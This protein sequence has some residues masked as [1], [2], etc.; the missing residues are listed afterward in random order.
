MN[1]ITLDAT[2]VSKRSITYHYN[3]NGEWARFFTARRKYTITYDQNVANV[4]LSICNIHFVANIL[5]LAWLCNATIKVHELDLEFTQSVPEI[6]KGYMDMYPKTVFSGNLAVENSI[7]N[8]YTSTNQVA[9][10]FSGGLDAMS[11]VASHYDEHPLLINIQGSD[12]NLC[13][14][15]IITTVKKYLTSMAGDLGL[16]ITFI[17]S[18]FRKVINEKRATKYIKPLLHDNYWHAMQHGIA[19]IS[20]AAPIAYIK[21][22]KT[23]YIASSFSKRNHAPCASD[24]TIDNHVK[25]SNTN[26]IHDGYEYDRIDK[27]R[28]IAEFIKKYNKKIKLRVCLDDYR[29]ENCQ[30]CEKCYRTIFD[31]AA[32]GCNP[33]LV[34]FNLSDRDYKDAKKTIQN[35]VFIQYPILWQDIQKAFQEHPDL[36]RNTRYAWMYD[37]DFDKVNQYKKK[38]FYKIGYAARKRFRKAL[39]LITQR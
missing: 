36:K 24:P 12:I 18:E 25:L 5:P 30:H 17:S 23:I 15:K 3:I 38:Y 29:V 31:F 9:A 6:K 10:F 7:N 39:R 33:E 19:I 11:T 1:T 2:K 32:N 4:P 28:V 35:R 8:T 27:S 21:K 20:H 16:P 13:Y 14:K 34:G 26:I 37:Y 22:L